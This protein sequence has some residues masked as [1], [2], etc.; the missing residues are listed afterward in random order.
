[1]YLRLV[2]HQIFKRHALGIVLGKPAVCCHFAG[3]HFEMILVANLLAG[4]D[5]MRT[6][7]AT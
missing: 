7:M 4:V 1:M 3:K 6:R 5:V 2:L